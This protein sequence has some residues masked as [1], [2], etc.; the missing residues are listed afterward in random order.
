VVLA[1]VGASVTGGGGVGGGSGVVSGVE[2]C[3]F[4]VGVGVSTTLR[5]GL[6][7]GGGG[8]VDGAGT[9]VMAL[10]HRPVSNS[11]VRF[12]RAATWLS[13]MGATNSKP[14]DGFRRAVAMSCR[15]AR[16]RSL[17]E[18]RAM[19]SF[20][21]NHETVFEICSARVLQYES[22]AGPVYQ[23]SSACGDQEIRL[24]GF[25]WKWT[26]MPGGAMSVWLNSKWPLSWASKESLGLIREPRS[27]LRERVGLL[28]AQDDPSTNGQGSLCCDA[29]KA[30]NEVILEGAECRALC[31]GTVSMLRSIRC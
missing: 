1:Q 24:L 17:D 14:G 6:S 30:S 18:A 3:T 31:G 12:F 2:N 10:V 11:L 19:V 22:R 13:V 7:V 25:S 9:S 15:V 26:R 23:P 8:G 28:G 29:A 16:M 27:K 5:G 21:G 4:G 20:V